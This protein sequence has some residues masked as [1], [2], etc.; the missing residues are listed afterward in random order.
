[1]DNNDT[2][3]L[4]EETFTNLDTLAKEAGVSNDEY[5]RALLFDRASEYLKLQK[6][7]RSLFFAVNGGTPPI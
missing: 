6:S 4:D 1:M 7:E 3:T 2:I 5:L